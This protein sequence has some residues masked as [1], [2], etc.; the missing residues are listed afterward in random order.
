MELPKED[1]DVLIIGSG[2]VGATYA[3]EILHPKSGPGGE[4]LK[5]IMVETGAQE[6]KVP[7]EHKKNAVAYQKHIDSFVNI[8]QGSLYATSVPTRVDAN[9]KLPPVAWSPRGE[10][11]FNGQNK[12]QNI[13]HNLDANGV[14]RN[15][16]GMSTHWTCAT[17]RQHPLERSNIFTPQQWKELYQRAEE[18]IGTGTDVLKDSI[19]QR[20]V[21]GILQQKFKGRG[22]KALPLA[23]EKVPGKNLI[24]WSSSSTVLGDLVTSGKVDLRD[25][26]ICEKLE[27]ENVDGLVK[28]K[29]AIIKNLAKPLKTETETDRVEIKARYVVICGGPILTPQLLYN[30]GF[31]YDAEDAQDAEG[32]PNPFYIPALGRYLTEQTM[33]FCQVVLKDEWVK[34][35]QKDDWGTECEKHRSKFSEHE[36]P[37]RIPFDDLDPQCTLP[38]TE[39]TPWHTQ[40]HRD[41][42]SYGAVPPAIDKRT[43]VDLRY[44]GRVESRWEN[45]V[46]FSKKLTDAY[47][48]PQP[49]FDF[50]LSTRDRLQSHRMM[51]DM[52]KVASELGGYLPGSEPQFLAPGLALHVCGT[53]AAGRKGSKSVDEMKRISVC[54]ELSKVWGIGN[55]YLGGLNV[56]PGPRGNAS[57]P[58][59]AAMCFAIKGAAQIRTQLRSGEAYAVDE[60]SKEESKPEAED[61]E[62]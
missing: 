62:E 44:F 17:P 6:S 21:L 56:V 38:F 22:A 43:I 49:T 8:I 11:N 57:N 5:I 2:P 18:L 47:G 25:Q 32:N 45:R 35:L 13:Y 27:F 33:C 15:V 9:L 30:S 34:K 31:R 24:N 58:T 16:G 28:V 20:L 50:T 26:H 19:R 4:N 42:F 40:I 7:G 37:L 53:T 46:T 55:L 39:D 41:A 48:M 59:L 61:D 23:A 10:Q 54:N 12:E 52:E 36:D 1:C 14:S 3:R 60:S 51:Q 29:S